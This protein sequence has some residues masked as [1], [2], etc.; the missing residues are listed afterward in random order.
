MLINIIA[1]QSQLRQLLP[2][3]SRLC[4]SRRDLRLPDNCA[5][6]EVRWFTTTIRQCYILLVLS[7]F[8]SDLSEDVS[9]AARLSRAMAE[10]SV[11]WFTYCRSRGIPGWHTGRS[12]RK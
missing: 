8:V 4:L 10:R 9:V 11:L 1:F 3:H 7:G 12:S 6:I 2:S 5:K